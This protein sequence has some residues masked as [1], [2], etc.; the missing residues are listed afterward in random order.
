MNYLNNNIYYYDTRMIQDILRVNLSHLKRE[1]KKYGFSSEDYIRHKNLHL[2]NQE[3]LIEF[4]VF[5]TNE[6]HV[7]AS[8][9]ADKKDN[10]K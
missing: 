5:L 2:Y 4:I 10:N 3:A 8:R 9:A 6:K 1:M 7:A